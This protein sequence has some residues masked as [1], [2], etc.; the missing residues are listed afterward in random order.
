MQLPPDVIGEL[1]QLEQRCALVQLESFT[2]G[3]RVAVDDHV[4]LP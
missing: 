3:R 4:T 1:P 2:K